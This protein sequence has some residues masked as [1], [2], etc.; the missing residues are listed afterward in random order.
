GWY[1]GNAAYTA[2]TRITKDVLLAARWTIKRFTLSFNS[3]GGTPVN[4]NSITVDSG[5]TTALPAVTRAA[6]TFGGW[7][8]G[9]TQY[10]AGTAIT[11]SVALTAKWTPVAGGTF[12]DSR[13]GGQT[14]KWVEIGTQTWMAENLNYEMA[15]SS[16][17][18]DNDPINCGIY[19][20]LYTWNRAKT[21]CPT[22]WHLPTRAEWTILIDYVGSASVAS[23]KLRSTS[24]WSTKGTDDYGFTALPGGRRGTDGIFGYF[25]ESMWWSAT[26]YTTTQAYYRNLYSGFLGDAFAEDYYTKSFGYSV[27]CLKD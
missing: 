1:D 3:N 20:R 25:S 7:F 27:R 4:I 13:G 24:G 5:M 18:Y 23:I 16:W 17:C 19:G 21:A 12:V 9:A 2:A 8:D 15:D 22:G 26:E 11:K 14:Y 10:T 6:H